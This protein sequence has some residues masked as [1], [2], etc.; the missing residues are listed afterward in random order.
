MKENL[1][2]KYIRLLYWRRCS[3]QNRY[4]NYSFHLFSLLC[5]KRP[6]CWKYRKWCSYFENPYHDAKIVDKK[7]IN[8]WSVLTAL[9]VFQKRNYFK[10]PSGYLRAN[11]KPLTWRQLHSPIVNVGVFFV[12]FYELGKRLESSISGNIRHFLIS[13]LESF[14]SG[15]MRNLFRLDFVYFFQVVLKSALG[16]CIYYYL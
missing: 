6:S 9:F 15:N 2:F 13:E 14:I 10:K 8:F 11:F 1:H 12:F 5:Q 7:R 3:Y 4:Q 16:S